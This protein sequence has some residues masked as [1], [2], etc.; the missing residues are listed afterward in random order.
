MLFPLTLLMTPVFFFTD[1]NLSG[2]NHCLNKA[3]FYK[4]RIIYLVH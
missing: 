2:T 3:W 4:N 1:Y